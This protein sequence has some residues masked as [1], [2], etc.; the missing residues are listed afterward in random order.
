MA[1]EEAVA[2]FGEKL[3]ETKRKLEKGEK[4]KKE[5]E[6]QAEYKLKR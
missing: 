6:K 1:K 4:E 5:I 3:R 2:K